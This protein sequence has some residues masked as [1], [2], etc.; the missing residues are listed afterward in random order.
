MSY[1]NKFLKTVFDKAPYGV[2]VMATSAYGLQQSFKRFGTDYNKQMTL[3]EES[4][5]WS[6]ERLLNYQ[7]ERFTIFAREVA[8]VSFYAKQERYQVLI[9]KTAH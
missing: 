8:D 1:G 4:Q 7:L 2:K 5:Y 6:E 9:R 3:L